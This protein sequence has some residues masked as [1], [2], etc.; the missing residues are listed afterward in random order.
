LVGC[1][2]SGPDTHPV[3]GKVTI[4]GV[5]AKGCTID[6]HPLETG[7]QMASG[8]IADDGSYTLLTGVSGTPGAMVGKYKV[9]VK[10]VSEDTGTG[11]EGS[12]PAY[13]ASGEDPTEAPA[14]QE[15]D[16]VP[17]EYTDVSTTPLEKEVTSGSNT[18]DIPITSGASADSAGASTDSE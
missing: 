8:V 2:S 9:V 18:I 5:A 4:D 17:K 14:S 1:G 13:M 15:S 6:F 12:E 7:N 3:T 16:V 10:A 11:E